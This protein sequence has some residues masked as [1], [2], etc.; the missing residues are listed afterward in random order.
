MSGESHVN[1]PYRQ[2]KSATHPAAMS[3]I[4]GC[5]ECCANTEPPK[6]AV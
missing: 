5:P 1:N 4:D 2:P 3:L 6:S